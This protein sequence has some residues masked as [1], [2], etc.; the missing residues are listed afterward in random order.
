VAHRLFDA[1]VTAAAELAIVSLCAGLG[2]PGYTHQDN[3]TLAHLT[4]PTCVSCKDQS[5]QTRPG[6]MH[7]KPAACSFPTML[8]PLLCRHAMAE[9]VPATTV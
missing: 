3:N 1:A 8:S 2:S 6:G 5:Y 9:T 7:V 4:L